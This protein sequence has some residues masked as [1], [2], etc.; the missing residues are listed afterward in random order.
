VMTASQSLERLLLM[1][2]GTTAMAT[3]VSGLQVVVPD[4]ST[5]T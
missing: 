4:L 3:I 2:I 5:V 1:P